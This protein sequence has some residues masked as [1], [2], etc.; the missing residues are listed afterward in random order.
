MVVYM[1]SLRPRSALLA[2][3]PTPHLSLHPAY[4]PTV[5]R[6]PCSDKAHAVMQ[7]VAGAGR[8]RKH[9]ERCEGGAIKYP[10]KESALRL[11]PASRPCNKSFVGLAR[12]VVAGVEHLGLSEGMAGGGGAQQLDI[13]DHVLHQLL[14]QH[15]RPEGVVPVRPRLRSPILPPMEQGRLCSMLQR[16]CP[17]MHQA[18]NTIAALLLPSH[19]QQ[20]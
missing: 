9:C 1:V 2:T 8:Q 17:N 5:S 11:Q 10:K 20:E 4:A 13:Q 12:A 14:G 15:Q 6:V 16:S 7:K 18:D 3:C 19:E